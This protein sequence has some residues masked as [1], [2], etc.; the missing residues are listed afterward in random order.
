MTFAIYDQ[1]MGGTAL[2]N[3][4]LT[5]DVDHG[6]YSVILGKTDP[7]DLPDA[8]PYWLG[9]TVGT[10]DEMIPRVEMTSVMYS[11]FPE[12]QQGPPGPAGPPG[13]PGPK[14]DQGDPGLPEECACDISLEQFEQLKARVLALEIQ[15]GNQCLDLDNDGYGSGEDCLGPDCHDDNPQINPGMGELCNAIDDNCNEQIDEGCMP[16][17][18]CTNP[19][20][21]SDL[22]FASQGDTSSVTDMMALEPNAC[23]SGTGGGTGAPDIVYMF[24]PA[25]DGTYRILLTDI[26]AGGMLYMV[27]DCED[28]YTCGGYADELNTD[29]NLELEIIMT[30][31]TTYFIIVDGWENGS[32]YSVYIDYP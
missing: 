24:T 29:N 6:K 19:I 32:G 28:M 23:G 27:S 11:L 15:L 9:I 25:F 20:V 17:D 18:D 3:E 5:V 14:G 30:S 4:T 10:D 21:I 1:A 2:W 22:P 7:I 13:P 26:P 8:K 31:D 16:G 12:G